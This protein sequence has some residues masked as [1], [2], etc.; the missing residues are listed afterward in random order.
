LAAHSRE[1]AAV[2]TATALAARQH[3]AA[4][5]RQQRRGSTAA[6]ALEALSGLRSVQPLNGNETDSFAAGVS[7]QAAGSSEDSSLDEDDYE[8]VM[9]SERPEV[10]AF[11]PS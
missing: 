2:A 5:S 9:V 7:K 8:S 11:A 10:H 6:K 4:R 1:G 3:V